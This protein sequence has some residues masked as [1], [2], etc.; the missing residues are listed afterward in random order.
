M[1]HASLTHR[2]AFIR[3]KE[4]DTEEKK[5]LLA[6]NY[7]KYDAPIVDSELQKELKKQMEGIGD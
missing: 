6:Y 7:F 2:T 4:A 1:I 5:M 3:F